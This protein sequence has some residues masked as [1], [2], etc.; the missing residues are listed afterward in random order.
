MGRYGRYMFDEE[1]ITWSIDG[2]GDFFYRPKH[3]FSVTNVCGF[4][5]L[6]AGRLNYRFIA[7]QLQRLHA[8]KSFDYVA[9]AHPSVIRGLYQLAI[10]SLPEQQKIADCLSSLDDL[11]RAQSEK[12]EALKQHKK[13]L[14]Q[15]LFPQEVG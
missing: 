13:G 1:L 3:K 7:G 4:I 8:L 6:D 15:Q 11:I 9:K 10:P 5:R 12:I 14:M 2:G